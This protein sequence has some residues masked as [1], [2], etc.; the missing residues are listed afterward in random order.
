MSRGGDLRRRIHLDEVYVCHGGVHER[1]MGG[2]KVIQMNSGKGRVE[3]CLISHIIR[4]PSS[5]L[6]VGPG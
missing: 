5:F 2:R 4:M 6:P 3:A 1:C